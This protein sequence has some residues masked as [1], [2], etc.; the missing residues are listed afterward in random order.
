MAIEVHP[1]NISTFPGGRIVFD[2]Y[3][4]GVRLD[5]L[6]LVADVKIYF[7]GYEP[8]TGVLN[9]NGSFTFMVPNIKGMYDNVAVTAEW[10]GNL[11]TGYIKVVVTEVGASPYSIMTSPSKPL[12]A[13][14]QA[15]IHDPTGLL[16][17]VAPMTLDAASGN[18]ILTD[19]PDPEWKEGVY[20]AVIRDAEKEKDL[21]QFD[22][23]RPEL[24]SAPTFWS[25]SDWQR[26]ALQYLKFNWMSDEAPLPPAALL[27]LEQYAEHW[28]RTVEELNFVQPSTR[29]HRFSPPVNW[30]S[31]LLKGTAL[32]VFDTLANRSV[33]IPK[34]TGSP[35]VMQDE[36]AL[37]GNWEKRYNVLKPDYDKEKIRLK[38][39]Y[40]PRP[41]V[42]VD[43]MLGW[44]GGGNLGGAAKFALLG[45]PSWFVQ[46]YSGGGLR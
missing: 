36:S 41:A 5:L 12:V 42:T 30:E 10:P 33:T 21:I 18:Y 34:W 38:K 29:F 7:P 4:D 1:G 43:P 32:K 6:A 44:L 27:T 9:A 19:S 28:V 24:A 31:T 26:L 11:E 45:R 8:Q 39:S 14:V 20:R 35:I 3:R 22:L 37:Q 23:D 2:A 40:L 46:S 15:Q 16:V 17:R 25:L 13:P